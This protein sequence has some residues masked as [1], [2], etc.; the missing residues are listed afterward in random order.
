MR[1]WQGR[2]PIGSETRAEG[3]ALPPN[4]SHS[5]Q[6]S[7]DDG[8]GARTSR[9]RGAPSCANTRRVAGRLPF[10]PRTLPGLRLVSPRC[11]VRALMN[12]AFLQL[13]KPLVASV[14]RRKDFEP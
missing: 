14:S 3:P 7:G 2:R 13:P 10:F 12:R 4:D 8:G 9:A 6:R 1:E 11:R 5:G